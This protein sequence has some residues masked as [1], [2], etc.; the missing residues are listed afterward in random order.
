[1]PRSLLYLH[2]LS[3]VLIKLCSGHSLL[4]LHSDDGSLCAALCSL[5]RTQL[6]LSHICP[7]LGK[8]HISR[9]KLTNIRRCAKIHLENTYWYNALWKSSFWDRIWVGNTSPEKKNKVNS[10][11]PHFLAI[12]NVQSFSSSLSATLKPT[13]MGE[14]AQT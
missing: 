6:C 14:N 13:L 1:M 11:R 3:F 7:H 2:F 10:W 4:L 8:K 12:N 9:N 5:C